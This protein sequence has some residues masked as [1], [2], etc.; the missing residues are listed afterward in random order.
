MADADE[1]MSELRWAILYHLQAI[2]QLLAEHG[3]NCPDCQ[4]HSGGVHAWPSEAT[5]AELNAAATVLDEVDA[6]G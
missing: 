2:D 3:R 5:L 4:T 1:G 6:D